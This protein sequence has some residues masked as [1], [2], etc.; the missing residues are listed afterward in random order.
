MPQNCC[1]PLCTK[2]LYR[3][4]NKKK[5]SCLKFPGDLSLKKRWLLAICCEEGNV[6]KVNQKTKIC[7]HHFKPED[8][9]KA[10]GGQL[11]FVKD[12]VLPLRFSWSKPSPKK[13]KPPSTHPVL[14]KTEVLKKGVACISSN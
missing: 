10:I 8:L 3:T 2:K 5:I 6:F 13:R 14:S 1:V 9:D 7:S 11:V 4:E 12:R